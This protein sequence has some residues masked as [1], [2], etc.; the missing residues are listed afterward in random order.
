[1]NNKVKIVSHRAYGFRTVEAYITA[2]WH[3]CGDLPLG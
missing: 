3:G 1:M 2:I